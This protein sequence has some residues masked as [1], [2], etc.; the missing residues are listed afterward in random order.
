MSRGAVWMVALPFMPG[1]EQSGH[2]PA[3]VI[4]D[5]VYGQGSPLVLVVP[6]TSQLAA[7]RFPA[8]VRIEP[9]ATNGLSVPSVALVFQTRATD[10]ERFVR[11]IGELSERDLDRVLAEL[12]HL[13]GRP[14]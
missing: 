4:Q 8:T 9:S 1:R 3:I 5:S 14:H 12:S 2:R 10:R 13:T 11:R 6:L 7:Q